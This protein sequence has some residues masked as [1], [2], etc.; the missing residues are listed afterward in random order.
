MEHFKVLVCGG[1]DYGWK[2]E[3]GVKIQDDTAKR[4]LYRALDTLLRAIEE[5][6]RN[7]VLIHGAATGADSLSD[8]WARQCEVEIEAYPA[9][10]DTHKRAAGFIRNSQMLKEG[11]PNL[12]LAFPG[13][14]GTAMMV[15]LAE[16]NGV[17]VRR[18]Y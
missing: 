3:N 9:D 16:K 15:S 11:K 2:V 18:Y 8:G 17:V 6:G 5:E 4:K 12:V 13:G 1:R 14:R 7:L 10:W